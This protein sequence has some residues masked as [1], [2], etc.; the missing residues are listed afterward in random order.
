M[1]ETQEG[2]DP[3]VGGSNVSKIAIV[4]MACRVPGA[5]SVD[6]F[7]ANLCGGVESIRTLSR[8]EMLAAGGRPEEIDDPHHVPCA[9]LVED[10]DRFDADFF[11]ITA[12]EAELMD[13][14]QRIFLECAW[15]ALEHAGYHSGSVSGS[16]GVFGGAN[17]NN[18]LA[19]NLLP[20]GVF[21][22]KPAVLQAVL[23][24]DKDYLA[25]RVA[26]KLN[27]R[28]PAYTVQSGC[29]TSLV[30]VHLASR[31]L[32]GY[33]C[34]MALAGGVAVDVER[35]R[36]YWAHEGSV[37]SPDG[38]CRAFDAK[39]RG[40]VFGNGA[41]IVVLKRLDDAERDGDTIYAVVLGSAVN[42]DGSAKV[43]F[44]A[45]GL[46]GQ[47]EVIAE[48]LADAGV[49]AD[50]I[51]LVEAH[52]TGTPLGDPIE[53]EALAKAFGRS[54]GR[55]RCAV[56]SVKTNIGH[57]DSAAGVAGL[58]KATLAL[59][60]GVIPPTL[61]FSEPNPKAA[62]G[63]T[64]FFVNAA[65]LDWRTGTR[66]G[67]PRR[68]GVSSFGMGGTNAHVVLEEA[69]PAS[70]E[71]ATGNCELLVW[72]AR[73]P[74]ALERATANLL[75]YLRTAPRDRLADIAHTLQV[76]R[77][78][79]A[80]RR[81]LACA[82][83]SA[84]VHALEAR[85]GAAA[86]RT[87]RHA[88]ESHPVAFVFPAQIAPGCLAALDGLY[89]RWTAFRAEVDAC[90]RELGETTWAAV[91][92]AIDAAGD[93]S[94]RPDPAPA[95]SPQ[96]ATFVV[97]SALA[98]LW[99]GWGVRP[100]AVLGHGAGEYVAAC[101]A[102]VLA[103]RDALAILAGRL[104]WKSVNPSPA[105]IPIL[106]TVSGGWLT[107][108]GAD[109]R[110]YWTEALTRRNDAARDLR[111]LARDGAHHVVEMG[112]AG[113]FVDAAWREE[114]VQT[115]ALAVVASLP[116]AGAGLPGEQAILD[117][118]GRLWQAGLAI[119]WP[120]VHE[121][122]RRVRMALPAYPF[123]RALHWVQPP[124]DED[125][126]EDIATRLPDPASWFHRPIWRQALPP[127]S[128]ASLAD[129]DAS[130]RQWLVFSDRSPLSSA[131]VARLGDIVG[132]DRVVT[133]T[134]GAR[135]GSQGRQFVVNPARDEDYR[136]LL[137]ELDASGRRP[138]GVAHL[139][140]LSHGTPEAATPGAIKAAQDAG[141][142][143]L[144]RL[145]SALDALEWSGPIALRLLTANAQD[146][147]GSEA[148]ALAPMTM[149][150]AARVI[151]QERPHIDCAS[152]DI[153][154]A[155][156]GAH[157]IE[158]TAEQIAS[159]FLRAEPDRFVAFRGV[160]RWVLAY[161]PMPL[162]PPAA[163]EPGLRERGNYLIV[164]GLGRIGLSLAE[165]LARSCRARL[166]LVGRGALPP[167]ETW[168][169][170][171]GG[172]DDG[173][174]GKRRA[175]RVLMLEELGA[176]VLVIQADAGDPAQMAGAL[177]AAERRF[178]RL[179]GVIGAAGIVDAA[180][181]KT[182][183]ALR[184]I[185]C[186]RQFRPK[187]DGLFALEQALGDRPLDF[188]LVV[189]SLSS[190]LGGLGY[191]AYAAANVLLDGFV[192]AHNRRHRTRWLAANFDAW[193]W[194]ELSGDEPAGNLARLALTPAE[195][196]GV[197]DR[198]LSARLADQVVISTSSLGARLNQWVHAPGGRP[199][200]DRGAA[201]AAGT[202][203]PPVA[204]GDE[205]SSLT[206]TQRVVIDVWRR[207]LGISDIELN[208]SFLDL[209]GS[210]LTAVQA[211]SRIEQA[212]GVHVAI[213]EFIFQ[214][215]AQLATLCDQKREARVAAAAGAGG[216]GL[217]RTFRD[218]VAG[219]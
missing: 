80:C 101:H 204:P 73:T 127:A 26:Y 137:A 172:A 111:A 102:G 18:Y 77:A 178:G 152:V 219:R 51:G 84:A 205:P 39:A 117:A 141:F 16:I 3:R 89:A 93:G 53:I 94:A 35:A 181:F 5:A 20:A 1:T 96:A 4:G 110:R 139:W 36:G 134:P 119:D 105:S 57:L 162:E 216:G 81:T 135:F 123:E 171:L 25:T 90:V 124:P 173:D 42:N 72:S 200:A 95:L 17:F 136:A 121:H 13:P 203:P 56:G 87:H 104:N 218:A 28:G 210:S 153:D 76:G 138:T 69:A 109:D 143:S 40:T 170:W 145:M 155:A 192:R 97:E 160:T 11:G 140:T 83:P 45:P 206:A 128:A 131:L 118:L 91:R 189:S 212:L 194:T 24:N 217:L 100:A 12:R 61:H 169:R 107:G 44:T 115:H 158:L 195:A 142:L 43:G 149:L 2:S 68:A 154:R 156:V 151:P 88:G 58:I 185:E 157:A 129:G 163:G 211:V 148:L 207:V 15:Q 41:G 65:P 112:T 62:F 190:V 164:G 166:A 198:L 49:A 120:A 67:L 193:R 23:A 50:S 75:A 199:G 180:A 106:S 209:G 46:V 187:L 98:A 116:G 6:Q 86:V 177:D 126:P 66:P 78:L 38:H 70:L 71:A 82:S 114:A 176:D 19:W 48:A 31:S 37:F 201:Q 213:E 32:L 99:I 14:Q 184:P 55:A 147:A 165:H 33:E 186:E 63:K 108:G 27:L 208:E 130:A 47:A 22:D 113:A 196:A 182:F 10:A 74:E 9:A 133:V 179:H 21:D 34:D 54:P 30:A 64:P 85:A 215:A 92:E 8:D 60:H 150:A 183:G 161:E 103:R 214:T 202:L 191:G 144:S 146:V 7:W 197:F 159:E 167:R 125:L 122:R 132:V 29:S 52:G 168:D 188:C 175:R 59:Y 79:F 174:P